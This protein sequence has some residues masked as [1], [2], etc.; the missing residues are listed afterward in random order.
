MNNIVLAAITAVVL[1][2][3]FFAIR[4]L[5]SSPD[6]VL[7]SFD[8]EI[9]AADNKS[10]NELLS[11]LGERDIKATF[12]VTGQYAEQNPDIVLNIDTQGHEIAGHS[13]S[14]PNFKRLNPGAQREEI[15]RCSEAIRKVT[16][17]API[18]FRAPW[19]QLTPETYLILKQEGFVYD[20]SHIDGYEWY[21]P[22][23]QKS[24]I[25][26]VY[27]SS[28][29]F[30]A[31]DIT[32]RYFLH[33]PSSVYFWMLLHTNSGTFSFHPGTVMKDKDRFERFLDKLKDNGAIFLTH[34][35]EAE[36]KAG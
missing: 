36:L 10:M 23:I 4:V 30:P 20:A 7:L 22:L 16:D 13:Y 27:T 21:F 24:T 19:R 11:I 17:V 29:I 25:K 33:V 31:D 15:R 26:E 35:E 8:V 34:G 32:M 28:F 18:G 2:H 9:V 14:H 3:V 6:V 12:F 5:D 1:V